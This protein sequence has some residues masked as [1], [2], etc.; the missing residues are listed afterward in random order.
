MEDKEYGSHDSHMDNGSEY[1]S[2]HMTD[3]YG[4]HDSHMDNSSEYCSGHMIDHMASH[5]THLAQVQRCWVGAWMSRRESETD[6]R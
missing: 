5:V 3:Q 4:S 2:G 6:K 1:C